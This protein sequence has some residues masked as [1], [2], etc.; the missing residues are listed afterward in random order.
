MTTPTPPYAVALPKQFANAPFDQLPEPL[1]RK[2]LAGTPAA[3]VPEPT[4]PAPAPEPAPA[5]PVE[6]AQV[7]LQLAED[8]TLKRDA[9]G[10]PIPAPDPNKEPSA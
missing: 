1:Q 7:R 9:D 8:G 6:P 5:A 2:V 4:T 3:A 10:N